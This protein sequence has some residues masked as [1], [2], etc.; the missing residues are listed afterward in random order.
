[1]DE[2]DLGR[3]HPGMKV[4]LYTDSRQDR[5][6]TGQIG[7]VSPRAEFTPKSVETKEL[8]T[9]LV[10]R[11]RIVVADPD[12]GLRQGMPVTVKISGISR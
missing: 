11:L 8:R 1:M 3:I 4:R 10:Y 9:A 12:E 2:P 6:Y 5:F 7:F